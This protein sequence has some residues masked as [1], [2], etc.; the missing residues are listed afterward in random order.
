[1]LENLLGLLENKAYDMDTYSVMVKD[2]NVSTVY[3]HSLLIEI[4]RTSP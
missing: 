4:L 2:H 1:M 3:Q